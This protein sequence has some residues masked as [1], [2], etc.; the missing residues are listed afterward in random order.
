MLPED[1]NTTDAETTTELSSGLSGEDLSVELGS[2]GT[3]LARAEL[4]GVLAQCPRTP[5]C[6]PNPCQ[7][8]GVCEDA[9]TSFV[10]T[11]PRPH[12]GDTCQY[13]ES[14]HTFLSTH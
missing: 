5:Q 13:S 11:C 12:L 10:C 6:V 7:A 3:M 2:D 8:D 4:H 9:W 1:S 14:P